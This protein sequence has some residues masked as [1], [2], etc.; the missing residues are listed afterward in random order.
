MHFVYFQHIVFRLSL[1]RNLPLVTE[2]RTDMPRFAMEHV[3][4]AVN[5]THWRIDCIRQETEIGPAI[6]F[7]AVVCHVAHFSATIGTSTNDEITKA[8][9]PRRRRRV[10]TWHGQILSFHPSVAGDNVFVVIDI[11]A[12]VLI[13]LPLST[14]KVMT[15]TTLT[16]HGR[17]KANVIAFEWNGRFGDPLGIGRIKGKHPCGIVISRVVG[18]GDAGRTGREY[19]RVG[20][21][22]VYNSPSTTART[23]ELGHGRPL[24]SRWFR[25]VVNK[26]LVRVWP[27]RTANV[28]T[29][30]VNLGSHCHKASVG[31]SRRKWNV[32]NLL[33]RSDTIAVGRVQGVSA[34]RCGSPTIVKA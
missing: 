32:V 18:S 15:L 23:G 26:A 10:T 16:I 22:V 1:Q 12:I 31:N 19:Q 8:E 25:V 11:V 28:A 5:V 3:G 7:N 30:H 24:L 2:S 20:L 21:C 9:G 27:G 29:A 14:G 13:L 6:R 34:H 17:Y 4:I 33:P